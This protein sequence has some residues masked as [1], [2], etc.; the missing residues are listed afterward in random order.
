MSCSFVDVYVL[1]FTCSGLGLRVHIHV[2]SKHYF[3]PG[4]TFHSEADLENPDLW[5]EQSHDPDQ[6]LQSRI[7][8]LKEAQFIIPRYGALFEI[9][10]SYKGEMQIVM[11]PT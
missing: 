2:F 9:P 3:H 1:V 5:I 7:D 6:Q 4:G 11:T 10:Q 8:I